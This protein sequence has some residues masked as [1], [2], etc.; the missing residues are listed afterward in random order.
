[1]LQGYGKIEDTHG[2]DTM[3]ADNILVGNERGGGVGELEARGPSVV[4]HVVDLLGDLLV[5]EGRQVG[6]GLVLPADQ[7]R[8]GGCR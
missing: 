3:E 5:C 2:G 1:M 4:D 6:E 7:R 8:E